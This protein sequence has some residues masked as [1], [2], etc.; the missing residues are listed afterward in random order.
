MVQDKDIYMSGERM[1]E[2][3]MGKGPL[4]LSITSTT[5]IALFCA[6]ENKLQILG[7]LLRFCRYF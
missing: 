5:S 7:R 1:S 4:P 6:V 2:G 3:E